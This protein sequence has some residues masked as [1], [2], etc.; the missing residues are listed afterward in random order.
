MAM[1]DDALGDGRRWSNLQRRPSWAAKFEG[2]AGTPGDALLK[3]T[4]TRPSELEAAA[5]AAARRRSPLVRRPSWAAKFEGAEVA[6]ELARQ[7]SA[8]KTPSPVQKRGPVV[9]RWDPSASQGAAGA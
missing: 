1:A 8:F 4:A 3:A 2:G 9:G 5:E 7:P 6:P